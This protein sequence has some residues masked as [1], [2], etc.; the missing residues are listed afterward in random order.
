MKKYNLFRIFKLQIKL[1]TIQ[2]NKKLLKI[3][4]KYYR[5]VIKKKYLIK[6][7]KKL[8][9]I[10]KKNKKSV[11]ILYNKMK[12]IKIVNKVILKL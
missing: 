1:I 8:I 12:I 2:K 5:I 7:N 3:I 11:K 9:K 4:K 6:N 10:I